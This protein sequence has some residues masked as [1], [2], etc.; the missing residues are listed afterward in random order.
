MVSNFVSGMIIMVCTNFAYPVQHMTLKTHGAGINPAT[1]QWSSNWV[2]Q[3]WVD[4][5]EQTGLPP[6]FGMNGV[7]VETE[8]PN[9]GVRFATVTEKI[10]T[11][12]V[13]QPP[14]SHLAEKWVEERRGGK[15]VRRDR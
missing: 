8:R 1:G 14:I 3:I 2:E 6:L 9:P 15:W 12:V 5:P 7:V 13:G 10:V 11:G 4:G